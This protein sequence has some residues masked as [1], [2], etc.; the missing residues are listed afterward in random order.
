L[1]SSVARLSHG[2]RGSLI[3]GVLATHDPA[4]GQ[5]SAGANGGSGAF[6]CRPGRSE[7]AH[8]YAEP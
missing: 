3:G 5:Q 6:S 7:R 2:L 4:R 1:N 8:P